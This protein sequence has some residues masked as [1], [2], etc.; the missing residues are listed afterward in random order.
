MVFN[1]ER[2]R[3]IF[4]L[5]VSLL[6]TFLLAWHPGFAQETVELFPTSVVNLTPAEVAYIKANPILRVHAESKWPPYNFIENG[7][8]RGFSNDYIQL[9][10]E[11]IGLQVEF[12]IGP[13]WDE[14]MTMLAQKKIDVVTNMAITEDRRK[15]AI[16][17][18]QY[19]FDTVNSLLTRKDSEDYTALEQLEGKNLAIV[20]GYFYEELLTRHYPK[21]NLLLTNNTLDAMKQVEAGRADAALESHATF[22]YYIDRYF[23]KDL[24]SR[25]LINNP[26]FSGATGQYLGI[27]NDRPILKSILDKAM[28]ALS[29]EE[30][31]NLRQRWYL[32]SDTA[33]FSF[34]KQELNYL[35]NKGKISLCVDPNWMPLEAIIDG[36]HTGMSA[37]F[38]QLLQ[39]RIGIPIILWQTQTWL[40][41]LEGLKQ[42]KCDIISLAV[43]TEER[44]QYANFTQPYLE[45]PLVIATQEEEPFVTNLSEVL[46]R[47]IGLVESYAFVEILRQ[48]YPDIQIVEVSSLEEG[49]QQVERG[50]LFGY[51]DALP[52]IS[53]GIQKQ[54][55]S[56]KIAGRFE[57][58]WQLG[59]AVRNDEPELL[60]IFEK[61]IASVEEK[62][63]QGILNNWIS[64][65]YE[66]GVDYQL[67]R[68]FLF[69]GFTVLGILLY[70][71]YLL[72]TYNRKL[73]KLSITDP[74]TGCFNRLHLEKSLEKQ[75]S[76]FNRYQQ[77]FSVILC[78]IDY[79]KK[80]NDTFGHLAG[81]AVLIDMVVLFHRRLR[82][83]DI[84]GRWGGEE[85]LIIAPNTNLTAATIL[86]ENLC[87]Q[88]AEYNF[89]IVGHQTASFGVAEFS[90]TCCSMSH[91]ISQVD[92]ALYQAKA[93]GR[94]CVVADK[95]N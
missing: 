46:D 54:Y 59:I 17:S 62:E 44:R 2:H 93:K 81:D 30:Y 65:R 36:K 3:F 87:K 51:V 41:S 40:E 39:D 50:E 4:S 86:A 33:S 13:T 27:R 29:E 80:I 52:T 88:L 83:T 90:L 91:F 43:A 26:Y 45:L 61:A 56:L 76:F 28:A 32:A 77:P 60:S 89:N 57:Q 84:L 38:I 85:F 16:Y 49:L 94:N 1:R 58:A 75:E 18:E 35:Q 67:I 24:V 95:Q 79:F 66:K 47:K 21:I 19:L 53:Y 15:F 55:L 82:S 6:L 78:D 25:P 8:V 63:K 34:T 69:I 72:Q 23:L 12:V 48:Q 20:R 11:K 22:K 74:L 9:I 68:R 70:R 10:A 31:E 64:V 71:Q 14:F 37:D 5:I 73:E 92:R 7:Q 42:R